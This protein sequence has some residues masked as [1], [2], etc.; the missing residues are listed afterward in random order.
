MQWLIVQGRPD[1]GGDLAD[2]TLQLVEPKVKSLKIANELIAE[3]LGT[4]EL[5]IR[6]SAIPL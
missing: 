2:L 3:A 6:V 1:L 5:S 4:R